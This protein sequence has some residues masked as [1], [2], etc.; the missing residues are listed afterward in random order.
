MEWKVIF[1]TVG[2]TEFSDL[3]DVLENNEKFHQYL[4]QSKCQKLIIQYGR[5]NH[6]FNKIRNYCEHNQIELDLYNFKNS[7]DSD[8]NEANL[9]IC[10]AGTLLVLHVSYSPAARCFSSLIHRCRINN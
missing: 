8:M 7:L 6:N 1:V 4:I 10:H 5:G 3:M 2:T 9:I